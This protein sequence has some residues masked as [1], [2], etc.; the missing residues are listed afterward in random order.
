MDTLGSVNLRRSA[1]FA[2]TALALVV[3]AGCGDEIGDLRQ[4]GEELREDIEKG[5]S[6]REIREQLNEIEQEARDQGGAAERE[7][8]ELRKELE[9]ELP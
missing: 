9:D 3:P 6:E 2:A 7:A 8:D 4:Q 1:V 5:A